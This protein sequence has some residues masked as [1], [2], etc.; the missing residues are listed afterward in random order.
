MISA[1]DAFPDTTPADQRHTQTAIGNHFSDIDED[2]QE[3]ENTSQS[4]DEDVDDETQPPIGGVS[5]TR[6]TCDDTGVR[7]TA[8]TAA[9]GFDTDGTLSATDPRRDSRAG[10]YSPSRLSMAPPP[11]AGQPTQTADSR[12]RSHIHVC[13]SSPS[14]DSGPR[15]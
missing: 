5:V 13:P 7:M 15:H 6:G 12:T 14:Y 10:P 4:L 8:D 1:T 2:E 11:V 9:P 3:D